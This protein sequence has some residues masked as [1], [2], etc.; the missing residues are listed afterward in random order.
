MSPE[1]AKLETTITQIIQ[2]ECAANPTLIPTV[3]AVTAKVLEAV[4]DEGVEALPIPEAFKSFV[5]YAV[6]D[7][8]NVVAKRLRESARAVGVAAGA[9]ALLPLVDGPE[10]DPT[11][12]TRPEAWR[13][14]DPAYFPVPAALRE[15]IEG[16]VRYVSQER[17]LRAWRECPWH[18]LQEINEVGEDV[19]V[20]RH[21]DAKE[22]VPLLGTNRVRYDEGKGWVCRNFARTWGAAFT[23]FSS[24]AAGVVV[25]FSGQHS[26]NAIPVLMDEAARDG[27]KWA[28][29]EPQADVLVPN[30]D[31]EHHYTGTTGFVTLA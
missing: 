29:V 26:Y 25:D 3:E 13:L 20:V 12:D 7:A 23:A 15:R 28:I 22:L 31:P 11:G 9:A 14:F 10:H 27:V 2:R 4:A 5:R 17:V 24:A 21:E 6:H 1:V 19:R 30:L 18:E 16:N 8:L